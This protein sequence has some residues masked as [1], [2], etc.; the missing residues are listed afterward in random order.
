LKIKKGKVILKSI[1]LIYI[2]IF[3]IRIEEKLESL[4]DFLKNE[5]D[6]M[7]LVIPIISK[8]FYK[9]SYNFKFYIN[10]IDDIKTLKIIKFP[11]H[12]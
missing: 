8:D 7:S 9:I 11:F 5:F 4:K 6:K 3:H 10:F 2:I 12:K 1:L